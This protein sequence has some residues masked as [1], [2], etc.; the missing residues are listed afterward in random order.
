MD[1]RSL[2][3]SQTEARKTTQDTGWLWIS[4]RT[5]FYLSHKELCHKLRGNLEVNEVIPSSQ[6]RVR[7][8]ALWVPY[9]LQSSTQ[10]REETELSFSR[11]EDCLPM[12]N[13]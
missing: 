9:F 7:R 12:V 8:L 11:D 1:R 3:I 6:E 10:I 13:K 5:H 2:N 4:Q